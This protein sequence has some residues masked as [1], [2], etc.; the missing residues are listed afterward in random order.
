MDDEGRLLIPDFGSHR[1]QVYKK[2]AYAL[3]KTDISP[4]MDSPDL[5]TV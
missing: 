1:I 4:V 2:E 3:T 5:Y